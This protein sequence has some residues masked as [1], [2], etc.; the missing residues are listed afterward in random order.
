MRLTKNY[1]NYLNDEKLKKLIKIKPL[2]FSNKENLIDNGLKVSVDLSNDNK[3]CA[4]VAKK[5]FSLFKF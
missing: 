5:T 2:I 3:I 4:Y 1:S